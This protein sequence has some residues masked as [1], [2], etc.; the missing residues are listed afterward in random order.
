MHGKA[1]SKKKR[2]SSSDGPRKTREPSSSSASVKRSKAKEKVSKEKGRKSSS[3][4][5]RRKDKDSKETKESKDKDQNKEKSKESKEKDE[6]EKERQKERRQDLTLVGRGVFSHFPRGLVF[7]KWTEHSAAPPVSGR[8]LLRVVVHRRRWAMGIGFGTKD[9]TARG[10]PE[11]DRSF[12]GLYHGGGSIN[13]CALGQRYYKTAQEEWPENRLAIL[14][15]SDARSMQCFCGLQPFGELF[16]ELPKEVALLVI[17]PTR[18]LAL[19]IHREAEML[20]STHEIPSMCMIGGTSTRHDQ[21]LVRRKKPRVLIATPGRLLEHLERTYLFPTLFDKLQTFV[22]DEADRLLS[23][24]FLPEVREIVSY[25]PSRRR[26]M[27]FSA[28]MPETVMDVI[29]KACRGNYRYIDCIEEESQSTALMAQQFYVVLPGHQ[30][31]AALYNL[32]INEMASNRYNY[33]ILVFFATARMTTFM[34]QFFRQ[35]LRIGVYEIHRRR[36]ALMNMEFWAPLSPEAQVGVFAV[37]VLMM[38]YL[39]LSFLNKQTILKVASMVRSWLFSRG[40]DSSDP[41]RIKKRVILKIRQA[42]AP[43]VLALVL[44]LT[45]LFFAG[46][47]YSGWVLSN[48]LGAN[49]HFDRHALACAMMLLCQSSGAALLCALR[50]KKANGVLLDLGYGMMMVSLSITTLPGVCPGEILTVVVCLVWIVRLALLPLANSMLWVMLANLGCSICMRLRLQRRILNHPGDLGTVAEQL[51]TVDLAV[52]SLCCVTWLCAQIAMGYNADQ[53]M[54]TQELKAESN[55]CASLLATICD[56]HFFLN[57]QLN[58][59]QHERTL[60][61]ILVQSSHTKDRS[62]AQFLATP[63]DQERFVRTAELAGA[64]H[65]PLAQVMHVGMRDGLGNVIPVQVFHIALFDLKGEAR[66]LVG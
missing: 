56:A 24:G 39:S 42:L 59:E 41:L 65:S 19:Q 35:Q 66:H 20:L 8:V 36:E 9:V 17:S 21:V 43:Y 57:K 28:T 64:N 12:F 10:D 60:S 40:P 34:A 2:K 37:Q 52:L 23:L 18:E 26:T 38:L 25:L 27:L 5:S 54:E 58:F 1:D 53:Q 55:A 13:C 7:N 15:D 46:F 51:V 33:K 6:K 50:W 62:F 61:S 3:S 44:W 4:P 29:S 14:I 22:L 11:Y 32:I 30:C 16:A 47:V 63:Q 31:L 49:F 45:S 48:S